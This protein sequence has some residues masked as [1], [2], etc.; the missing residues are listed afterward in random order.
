VLPVPR[1]RCLLGL[2][3]VVSPSDDRQTPQE[4][5]SAIRLPTTLVGSCVLKGKVDSWSQNLPQNTIDQGDDLLMYHRDDFTL[6]LEVVTHL[7][8]GRKESTSRAV[9]S[10]PF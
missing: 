6:F 7:R 3:P 1:A 9:R 4:C 8:E 2:L 5:T 10:V